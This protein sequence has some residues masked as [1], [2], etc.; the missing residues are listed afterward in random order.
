[1]Q[2]NRKKKSCSEDLIKS[3]L[4]KVPGTWGK[5]QYVASLREADGTYVHWGLA[6]LHGERAVHQALAEVHTELLEEVLYSPL[7]ELLEDLKGEAKNRGSSV[8]DYLSDL[9]R[10]STELLPRKSGEQS[11]R[12][13]SSVLRALSALVQAELPTRTRSKLNEGPRL[14][15][16][17]P[18]VRPRA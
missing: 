9:S 5:L 10:L 8:S 1:M 6:C 14:A 4:A 15:G 18:S 7:R 12:R 17:L 2:R 3:I 16:S 11:R 13:F